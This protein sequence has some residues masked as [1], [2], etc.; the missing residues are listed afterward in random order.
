[1]FGR[2]ARW[3]SCV[4]PASAVLR[5]A[6]AFPAFAF[7]VSPTAAANARSCESGA[8]ESETCELPTYRLAVDVTEEK[9]D[10]GKVWVI[11][12]NVPGFKKEELAIELKDGVLSIDAKRSTQTTSTDATVYRRERRTVNFSRQIQLPE[13]A[14]DEGVVATLAD[15]VLTVTV[16]Q[17]PEALP[18]KI[19]IG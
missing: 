12:A 16:P 10:A 8:C 18:R 15:G 7:G 17:K 2:T 5:D 6:F 3:N 13:T 9:R 19:S 14:S 11:V 4:S 1:M